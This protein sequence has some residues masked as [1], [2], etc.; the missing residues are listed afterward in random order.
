MKLTADQIT[1]VYDELG[2]MRL[3]F[4][5]NPNRGIQYVKERV[6]LCK[7][8]RDRMGELLLKCSRAYADVLNEELVLKLENR[9]SPTTMLQQRIDV[10]GGEVQ[11]HKLLVTMLKTQATLLSRTQMDIRLLAS[12]TLEQIKLG[13]I[14]PKTAGIV[15]ELAP[16][17]VGPTGGENR[18]TS[19][20][21]S[22]II[23]GR[24]EPPAGVVNPEA[25][26]N[27]E[28]LFGEVDDGRSTPRV[29]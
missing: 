24:T 1:A 18:V 28:D 10:V 20:N 17:D 3:D 27:F 22:G 8:L 2:T 26:V 21:G 23:V 6:A 25:P 5:P 12:L 19:D 4:D 7:A 16:T 14:D 9:L 15:Q 13:E 29:Y 11:D